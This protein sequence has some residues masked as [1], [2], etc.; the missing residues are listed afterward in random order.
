QPARSDPPCGARAERGDLDHRMGAGPE[1]GPRRWVGR[2]TPAWR[3]TLAAM[4]LQPL[5]P[6]QRA[7]IVVPTHTARHLALC[8][9]SLARQQTPP[10]TIVVTVDGDGP[11]VEAEARALW[12][13]LGPSRRPA[14]VLTMRPHGGV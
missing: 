14:L 6:D 12:D 9:A 8:L 7:H 11:E 4:G 3:R 5:Q 13:R 1:P 2:L 10:A